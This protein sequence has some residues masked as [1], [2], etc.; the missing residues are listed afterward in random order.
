M[1]FDHEDH[2]VISIPIPFPKNEV[3]LILIVCFNFGLVLSV[4]SDILTDFKKDNV[5]TTFVLL[6]L[7]PTEEQ[8]HIFKIT[9][10]S[11]LLMFHVLKVFYAIT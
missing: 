9:R 6:K 10:F 4:N 5:H 11:K 2:D 3:I 7:S 8:N 1:S